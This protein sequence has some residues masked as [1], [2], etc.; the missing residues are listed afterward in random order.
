MWCHVVLVLVHISCIEMLSSLLCLHDIYMPDSVNLV[1]KL[2]KLI[3][4]SYI[5]D[6]IITAPKI[7]CM[8]RIALFG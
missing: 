3:Y 8:L 7:L 6:Y 4:K 5:V 1:Y 2:N